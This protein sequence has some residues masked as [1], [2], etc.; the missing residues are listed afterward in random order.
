MSNKRNHRK[1]RHQSTRAS[2]RCAVLA[3]SLVLVSLFAACFAEDPQPDP[4]DNRN[5]DIRTPDPVHV[6]QLIEQLGSPVFEERESAVRTLREFGPSITK[7]LTDAQSHKSPEVRSRV[8][9]LRRQLDLQP[10]KKAFDSFAQRADDKLD[11]EE[12]MWLISRILDRNAE[13]VALK[14]ELDALAD[15]VR[16]KLGKGI[17]PGTVDPQKMVAALRAVLFDDE[18][19]TGNELDYTH[20]GNSSLDVVLKTKKGL[21]I[22]L[23]HVV[24]AV[25]RRLDAPVVGIPAPGRYLVKYDG[26]KAPAGFS[27]DDIFF[28][29]FDHGVVLSQEEQ[30]QLYPD[31]DLGRLS[32]QTSRDD[33]IRMLNNIETHLFSHDEDEKGYMAVEF[34]QALLQYSPEKKE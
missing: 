16:K 3:V 17:D 31:I 20:P 29:P 33:L 32:V 2:A 34:R 23:S 10:L 25:A 26:R 6:A 22:L 28:D 8:N 21:P 30:E 18:K 15:K 13:Q 7:L 1:L 14:R 24:I 4:A 27:H 12:G 5:P 11:V 19:F 9:L